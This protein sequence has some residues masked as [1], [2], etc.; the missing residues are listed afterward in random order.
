MQNNDELLN[1]V[2]QMAESLKQQEVKNQLLGD[3]YQDLLKMFL[4]SRVA[5]A[6]PSDGINLTV[7]IFESP[8]SGLSQD[9]QETGDLSARFVRNNNQFNEAALIILTHKDSYERFS[10]S[11]YINDP[12][13]L[14]GIRDSAIYFSAL[15]KSQ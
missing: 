6:V 5:P 7:D 2:K 11:D 3:Q 12:V 4:G 9:S 13:L 8:L 15:N 1:L 10:R 14:H